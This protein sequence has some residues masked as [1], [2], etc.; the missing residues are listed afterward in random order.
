MTGQ[1]SAT[2][3]AFI[4]GLHTGGM[5]YKEIGERMKMP[6]RTISD[7]CSRAKARGFDPDAKPLHL[8]E[9]CVK[10]ASRKANKAK[11]SEVFGLV[12]AHANL[13]CM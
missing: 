4:I 13:V 12:K 9:A 7:I 5:A 3:Y 11:V 2:T 8:D 10:P 6:V 1:K